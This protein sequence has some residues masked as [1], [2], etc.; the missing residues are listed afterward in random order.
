M[1]I[2]FVIFLDDTLYCVFGREAASIIY[3]KIDD[4][5]FISFDKRDSLILSSEK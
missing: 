2:I 5:D 3:P 1:N 4:V